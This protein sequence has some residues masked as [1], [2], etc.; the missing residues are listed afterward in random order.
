MA[1]VG[2]IWGRIDDRLRMQMKRWWGESDG[3]RLRPMDG[4][5]WMVS[6]WSLSLW[7]LYKGMSL[8][9]SVLDVELLIKSSFNAHQHHLSLSLLSHHLSLPDQTEGLL[10]RAIRWQSVSVVMLSLTLLNPS[11]DSLTWFLTSID[12]HDHSL[13]SSNPSTSSS[14]PIVMHSSHS[15]SP[16]LSVFGFGFRGGFKRAASFH[17]TYLS[18][19]HSALSSSWSYYPCS[20]WFNLQPHFLIHSPG[21]F[22]Q[23]SLS[24]SHE[25]RSQFSPDLNAALRNSPWWVS[26]ILIFT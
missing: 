21:L 17:I 13:G 9:L 18:C 14:S 12:G 20:L 23:S 24:P 26:Q 16:C 6:W 3:L 25:A 4:K 8:E 5:R 10:T 7:N 19:P 22:S 15:I 11:T 2:L 1:L